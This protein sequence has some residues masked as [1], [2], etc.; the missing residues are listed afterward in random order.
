MVKLRVLFLLLQEIDVGLDG[1]STGNTTG[2]AVE[3]LVVRS[4]SSNRSGNEA[5][6][7]VFIS[8]MLVTRVR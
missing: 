8:T 4:D 6:R 1:V 7:D 2:L 5:T 3:N